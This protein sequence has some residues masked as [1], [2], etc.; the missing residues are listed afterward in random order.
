M[1]GAGQLKSKID[2]LKKK[3][4]EKGAS[5][6]PGRRRQLSKRLK[7]L[8][9]ARRTAVRADKKREAESGKRKAEAKP[10]GGGTGPAPGAEADS[11]APASAG[12]A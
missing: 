4:A 6:A 8:Q 7:R 10:G 5:L 2:L 1:A 3:M 11:A 12:E 9:R